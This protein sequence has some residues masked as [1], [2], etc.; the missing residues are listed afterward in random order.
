MAIDLEFEQ[1]EPTALER[2]DIGNILRTSREGAGMSVEE[3]ANRL[4]LRPSFIR[5]VESGE[6]EGQ[7]AWVYE[8]AHIRSM[9]A[10]FGIELSPLLDAQ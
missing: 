5:A 10:V 8:R 1:L 3:L 9:L 6:S 7:M 2:A 4:N